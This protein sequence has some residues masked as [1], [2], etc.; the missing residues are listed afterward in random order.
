VHSLDALVESSPGLGRAL[1]GIDRAAAS[2]APVLIVGESGTGRSLLAQLVHRASARPAGPLVEVDLAAIPTDLFESE[3]F[4]HREGAFT[5]ATGNHPGRVGRAQGGT[6]V[7][8]QI[9]EVPLEVQPKLLRLVS[10]RRFSP[11]GGTERAADVRLVS[12]GSPDL[13]ERVA[14]G[15]LRE[16]LFYRLEVLAFRLP[17]LRERREDLPRLVDAVLED[18]CARLSRP[19]PEVGESALAWML[20]Y[21]WP[22]NLRQLR[23]VLERAL[24]LPGDGPLAP[25]PPQDAE[26]APRSLEAVERE[27]IV[28][29]LRYTRGRQGRAAELLGISRK[30]LWEKRRRYGLP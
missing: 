17:S 22:G 27:Q 4:G 25:R 26:A 15:A 24:I 6:L 20:E 7:L 2:S 8:D 12:I 9:E 21:N 23:N 28:R 16:D 13:K 10:E 29:A 30:T 5:G 1:R 19:V 14:R 11:L 18:L 3:L